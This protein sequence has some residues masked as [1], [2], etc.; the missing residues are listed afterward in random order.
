M[1]INIG[2]IGVLRDKS[3]EGITSPDYVVFRCKPSL[4][5]E[6][7]YHYLKSEAGRHEINLKTKG[8]VRFRL[9]YEQLAQIRIP[10]PGNI[11]DQQNFVDAC[12]QL[13][14]LRRKVGAA[15]ESVQ[16]CLNAVTRSALIPD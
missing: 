14:Q 3:H 13:E 9:Y 5:P 7:V 4:L 6:F 8:S 12:N 2:S 16:S 1:R 11:Q 10:V 15:T